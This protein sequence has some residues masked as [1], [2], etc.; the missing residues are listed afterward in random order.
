[1]SAK[2]TIK[3]VAGIEG[4]RKFVTETADVP[5]WHIFAKGEGDYTYVGFTTGTAR[6]WIIKHGAKLTGFQGNGIYVEM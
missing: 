2:T 1:M 4:V 6:E 5:N 3:T